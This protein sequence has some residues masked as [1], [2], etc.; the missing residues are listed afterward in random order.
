MLSLFPGLFAFLSLPASFLIHAVT[1]SNPYYTFS[2][3]R[4]P[5]TSGR[6]GW[7]SSMNEPDDSENHG[8]S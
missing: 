7:G 2:V 5:S 1:V 4:S 6:V 8:A 3:D